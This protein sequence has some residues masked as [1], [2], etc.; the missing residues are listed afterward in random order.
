MFGLPGDD[1]LLRRI[2]EEELVGLSARY[3][4]VEID[5]YVIM[6]NHIHAVLII[7]ESDPMDP[8][9]RPTLMQIVGLFKAG[10]T[11]RIRQVVPGLQIWQQS[12]YDHVIRKKDSYV[13]ISR[14][15]DENPL[16]WE[17]DEYYR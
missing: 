17:H 5:R 11:K 3:D 2:V 7:K 1:N 9:P 4:G 12:F 10:V 6:P 13:R 14:Y 8:K 15:I 16:R